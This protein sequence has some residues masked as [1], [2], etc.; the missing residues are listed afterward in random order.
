MLQGAFLHDT[1]E[2][3]E[4][5]SQEL[6]KHFG[7]QVTSLVEELTDDKTLP[8]KE[9]KRRQVDHAPHLSVEA[10]QIKLADKICNIC[11]VTERDPAGWSVERK[12]EYLDWGDQVVA[13]LRGVN[14]GLE[15]Y[16]DRVLNERREALRFEAVSP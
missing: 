14:P 8:Q 13:G 7:K 10:K 1:L 6:Q 11:D 4:T 15:E 16:F 2:D 3:T 9:R 5:T 12:R